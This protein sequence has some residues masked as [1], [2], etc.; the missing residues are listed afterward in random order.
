VCSTLPRQLYSWLANP[1]HTR[2]R[3]S[4]QSM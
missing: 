4:I 2:H 1:K 3:F